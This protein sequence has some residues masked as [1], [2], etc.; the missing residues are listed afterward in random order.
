MSHFV[1]PDRDIAHTDTANEPPRSTTRRKIP[2]V[3]MG[4]VINIDPR[5]SVNDN[6]RPLSER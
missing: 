1:D 6:A 5:V 2:C 3:N 4:R